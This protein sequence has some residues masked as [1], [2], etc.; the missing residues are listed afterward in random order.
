VAQGP[1]VRRL[2][3]GRELK[4]L[5]EE[6][7]LLRDA[8]ADDLGRD[9]STISKIENGKMTISLG[10]VKSLLTLYGIPLGSDD[11]VRILDVAREARKRSTHRVPDWV[12]AFV[13]LEAEAVEMKQFEVAL[14]PGLLQ[15]ESYIRAM[16]QAG[17]PTRDPAEVERLVAIRRERQAR[18][19]GDNPP[20]LWVVM[21]EAVIRRLVGFGGP[22]MLEQLEH[23]LAM[24]ELPTVSVRIIP[25]TARP[26]PSMGT[27]FEI[28]RLPEP[29]GT[30]VV[31]L[32]D[33]WSADYVDRDSQV[34]AYVQVFDRLCDVALDAPSTAEMLK[35]AV[36]ELR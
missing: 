4:R 17:D 24:A 12:R 32:E 6:A 30:E 5:R 1:T 29:P 11:A 20:R 26:H 13:G 16:T 27:S 33:L 8:A 19:T 15:T 34:T 35:E 22:V 21:G 28:L 7:G 14:V 9:A 31:Y 25:F 10:D 36:G 2:Q 23:L 3:L 18:L